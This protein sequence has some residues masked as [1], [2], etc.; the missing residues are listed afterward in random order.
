LIAEGFPE[1]LI[2]RVAHE[3]PTDFDCCA[4]RVSAEPSREKSVSKGD[5]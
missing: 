1:E 2:Q 5:D 4:Q 3:R